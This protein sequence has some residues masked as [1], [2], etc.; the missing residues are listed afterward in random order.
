M[1]PPARYTGGGANNQ[2]GG[3]VENGSSK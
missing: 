3:G 1:P 2:Y